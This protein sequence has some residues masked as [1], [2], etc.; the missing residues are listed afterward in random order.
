MV[1]TNKEKIILTLIILGGGIMA[2]KA[3]SVAKP[4]LIIFIVCL[5]ALLA[6]FTVVFLKGSEFSQKVNFRLACLSCCLM[7]GA[8]YAL[9]EVY[10][11]RKKPQQQLPTEDS[12]Y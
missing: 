7:C 4:F 5:C 1:K 2:E 12:P 11:A 3:R 8:V 9:Y 6:I 10:L